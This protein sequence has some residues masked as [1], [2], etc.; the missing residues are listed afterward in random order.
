MVNCAPEYLTGETDNL[1]PLPKP[2]FSPCG[3]PPTTE[4]PFTQ[5]EML[6]RIRLLINAADDGGMPAELVDAWRWVLKKRITVS[7]VDEN[8]MTANLWGDDPAMFFFGA[9][10]QYFAAP[11][12]AALK[13]VDLDRYRLELVRD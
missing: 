9:A 6:A 2:D 12:A 11:L 3:P 8:S 7:Q 4:P 5:A 13:N 10:V 1:A